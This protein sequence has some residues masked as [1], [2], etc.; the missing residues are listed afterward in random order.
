VLL[1]AAIPDSPLASLRNFGGVEVEVLDASGVSR[2]KITGLSHFAYL[3]FET[4]GAVTITAMTR[5]WSL[6][7]VQFRAYFIAKRG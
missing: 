1:V 5:T 6:Y 3:T 2:A 4:T 7:G